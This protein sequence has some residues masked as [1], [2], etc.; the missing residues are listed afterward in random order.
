VQLRGPEL[1]GAAN[2]WE[3]IFLEIKKKNSAVTKVLRSDDWP[4]E[5]SCRGR[6]ITKHDTGKHA[7]S[8]TVSLHCKKQCGPRNHIK[9]D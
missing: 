1:E 6:K 9:C 5:K 4:K 7:A 3:K 8:W 2:E